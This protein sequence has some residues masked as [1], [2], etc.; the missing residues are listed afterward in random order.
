MTPFRQLIRQ[1]Q[2]GRDILA[3]KRAMVAM[4]VPQSGGMITSGKKRSYAGASFTQCVRNVQRMHKIHNDGIYGKQAHG[5]VAPHFDTYGN[6][7]YRTAKIRQ[8]PVPAVP[9]TAIGAAKRL[10][11]LHEAG[12]YRDDRGTELA[13]IQRTANGQGVWS[14]LGYYVHLDAQVLEA[15][16]WL[17]D[18]KGHRIGT[19]ALCTDHGPDGPHGH[20]GGKA[21]DISSID[22]LSV[23]SSEAKPKVMAVL[24]ALHSAPAAQKPWQLISGGYANHRDADCSAKSIP[25]ADGYYGSGTM[26][27]HCNHIHLGYQ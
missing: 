26:L 23:S 14:P 16:C 21:V 4:N 27:Q 20:G 8:P 6:W 19:F 3:V 9:T 13:Q 1:G 12:K 2:Q 18:Q 17:I 11:A 25:G 24:N 15:L 22:G 7:L 10:L 5:I